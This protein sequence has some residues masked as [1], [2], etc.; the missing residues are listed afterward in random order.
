MVKVSKH[1]S[2]SSSVT[3]RCFTWISASL[4]AQWERT[5]LACKE[6]SALARCLWEIKLWSNFILTIMILVL[7]AANVLV[8]LWDKMKRLRSFEWQRTNLKVQ[9]QSLSLKMQP[10]WQ[11]LA[12]PRTTWSMM[13]ASQSPS[14]SNDPTQS[15]SYSWTTMRWRPP[16]RGRS[17]SASHAAPASGRS[18]SR[19]IKSEIKEWPC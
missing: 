3:P 13:S 18:I 16:V 15:K 11:L 17:Q 1:A 12:S 5:H 7:M 8:L 4:K 10:I 2:L 6:R 14:S 9:E 19:L